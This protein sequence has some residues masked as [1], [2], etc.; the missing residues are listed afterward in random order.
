LKTIW[1]TGGSSGI[2][3][4]VAKKFLN[5]GWKVIISSKNND[6]LT[7]AKEDILK[8]IENKEIYT[9]K[10]DISVREEVHKTVHEIESKISKIDLALLN[11]A[12]YSPN[13]SQEFD[14]KNYELLID[15]NIK[16]TL[17]CIE[18]LQKYMKNR[19]NQIAIVSSPV[20]YRG[21]P[22]AGAYGLTKAGLINLAESLYFD[23]Q[24][25]KIKISVINPG[26]IESKSTNLNTFPM[27]FIKSAEF[28]ANKIFQGLTKSYKFE[29]YFPFFFLLI[30]KIGRILP[31]RLYF[32]LIKKIT[33]L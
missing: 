9:L 24:K 17:Y 10:C 19:N 6:N 11:A 5:E 21:L 8:N 32:Y 33:K 18:I 22:T 26:F 14:I 28:A 7:I 29:I 23:M 3:L 4:A 16:G 25:N 30:M 13:K 27:P 1:I 31:Y 2:G 20:G 12:A 15:V